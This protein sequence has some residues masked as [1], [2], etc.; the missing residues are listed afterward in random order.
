MAIYPI[1]D[2][3]LTRAEN[4]LIAVSLRNTRRVNNPAAS[5]V[6]RGS[7]GADERLRGDHMK[8]LLEASTAVLQLLHKT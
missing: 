1:I 7:T 4:A 5:G 6:R 8:L 2:Y 3:G